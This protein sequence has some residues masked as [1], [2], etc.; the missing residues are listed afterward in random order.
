[1]D[2]SD[3]AP[4]VEAPPV[5]KFGTIIEIAGSSMPTNS[6]IEVR[7]PEP[8]AGGEKEAKKMKIKRALR[9]S[10]WKVRRNGPNSLD[11]ELGENSFNN[12]EMIK[13]LFEGFT[14]SDV[15]D[16][17]V[18]ADVNQRAWDLLK[19]FLEAQEDHQDKVERLLKKRDEVGYSLMEK[20]IKIEGLQVALRKEREISV[21]LKT[22]LGMKGEQRRKTKAETA[23]PKEQISMQISE[24]MAR[25]IEEF[26]V[27][28]E[29]K[30]LNVKFGQEAFNKG[31][32][33]C[34]NMVA[35]KFYKLDL[36]F[37]YGGALEDEA[38]P[39][40]DVANPPPAKPTTEEPRPTN[41]APNSSSSLR[42]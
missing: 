40:I 6:P 39:S 28:H 29:I 13:G 35:N 18:D 5:I 31:F 41:A 25:A 30:D 4:E 12:H 36:D 20:S 7:I 26:M 22:T 1:M 11:E 8:P 27:S 33:L 42:G 9:K 21:E 19:S 15:V 2:A 24:A 3:V 17:I 37:L 32:E 34:K 38:E 14:I 10:Q 23:K 16:R